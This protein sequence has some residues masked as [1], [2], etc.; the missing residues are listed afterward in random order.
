[1]IFLVV[2]YRLFGILDTKIIKYLDF[3]EEK[4]GQYV[5]PGGSKILNPLVFIKL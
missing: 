4:D 5:G 3:F 2:Q 1:M